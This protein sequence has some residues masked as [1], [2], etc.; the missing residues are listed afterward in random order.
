M[1]INVELIESD[2][3]DDRRRTPVG[4]PIRRMPPSAPT[5][6]SHVGAGTGFSRP[7]HP[8]IVITADAGDDIVLDVQSHRHAD[9]TAGAPTR[10]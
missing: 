8:V 9:A 5:S 6:P 7:V 1:P 3:T 10:S 2:Y 4:D